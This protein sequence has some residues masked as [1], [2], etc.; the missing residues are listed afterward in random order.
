MKPSERCPDEKVK[1]V[2]YPGWT[3]R[4]GTVKRTLLVARSVGAENSLCTPPV[5]G[6]KIV[7]FSDWQDVDCGFMPEFLEAVPD[8]SPDDGELA[9]PKLTL[10]DAYLLG[11]EDECIPEP[12]TLEQFTSAY[13]LPRCPQ[14]GR[15]SNPVA[16]PVPERTAQHEIRVEFDSGRCQIYEDDKLLCDLSISQCESLRDQLVEASSPKP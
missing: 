12:K 13:V 14:N 6:M 2:N 9:E 10:Y 5:T 16:E 15:K 1:V 8:V 4:I 7:H 11:C 3:G